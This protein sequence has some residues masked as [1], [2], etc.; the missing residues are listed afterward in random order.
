MVS[1]LKICNAVA[2][3][4]KV[5]LNLLV[6]L[7]KLIETQSVTHTARELGLS[8]SA[9]SRSLARLRETFNDPLLIKTSSGMSLT[10]RAKDIEESLQQ[11]IN[12]TRTLLRLPSDD[13]PD[14]FIG[15]FRIASTDYGVLTVL[16]PAMEK[17]MTQAPQVRIEVVPLSPQH[18]ND[19]AGGMVDIVLTGYD[20]QPGRAYEQLL[21]AENFHCVFR[22][23]HPLAGR[24]H[25]HALTV[26]EFT[27]WPHIVAKVNEDDG[28]P[29]CG[30]LSAL[31]RKR[32]IALRVP[33]FSAAPHVLR[34]CDAI[35][36]MPKRAADQF[37]VT[38]DLVSVPA[39]I[40]LETFNYWILW[41]ERSR[42]D[43]ATLWLVEQMRIGCR[44]ILR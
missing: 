19:L 18:V 16:M 44:G 23:G 37:T 40:E 41:H 22:Q 39:P 8:Q 43:P 29:V 30:R 2:V 17:I 34:G 20:P 26:E 1:G 32:R 10:K 38:C 42:R 28:D 21:F 6:T 27:S 12:T 15:T 36:V 24:N 25:Q 4:Q 35:M 13:L 9:V 31:G 3:E 11:W 14:S 5:D 33:Y 7:G